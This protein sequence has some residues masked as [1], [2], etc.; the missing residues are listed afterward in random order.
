MSLSNL[1]I[2]TKL[3]AGFGVVVGVFLLSA[4]FLFK[5]LNNK[6]EV[7]ERLL[8]VRTPTVYAGLELSGAINQSL[9]GLRGYLI[10]GADP[11]KGQLFKNEREVA[12]VNIDKA[13]SEMNRFAQNWTV[14]KNK[15]LLSE[16]KVQ[17]EG[18]R[19]AQQSIEDIAHTEEN[20]PS[21]TILLTQAAPLAAKLVT[22][23]TGIINDEL[24]QPT[25][26]E[27][28]LFLKTLADSR[29]SFA[30]GLANIR[31]YLLSGDDKFQQS[32]LNLWAK[33]DEQFRALQG[34]THLLS[35]TQRG[36]WQQY[37]APRADFRAYVETMLSSRGG[38]EWNKANFW[39]GTKAAPKAIRIQ[40]I[41]QEMRV[42]QKALFD[43]EEQNLDQMSDALKSTILMV[44]LV[45]L[46]VS[47]VAA[48]LIARGVSGPLGGEP[49]D[50]AALA[51]KIAHGDLSSSFSGSKEARGLYRSM[52]NMNQKLKTLVNSIGSASQVVSDTAT[53]MSGIS[54]QT[55]KNVQEQYV[56]TEYVATAIEEMTTTVNDI[57]R[58][59]ADCADITTLTENITKTGEDNVNG[60]IKTIHNLN[61]EINH[62]TEV[63]VALQ[64]KSTSIN[65]VSEVIANIAEQTN[66]LALNAAIEAARAGEQGR[67]FAVVAD[68]VRSLAS[69]TQESIA[70]INTIIDSLQQG[71]N[72]AVVVMKKS[73]QEALA[74]IDEAKKS[75]DSLRE[76]SQSVQNIG[77][78]AQQIAVASEE[79]S[80]VITEISRNV[81]EISNLA[82]LTS[83]GGPK[84]V[85]ASDQLSTQAQELK[86][87]ISSFNLGSEG[88]RV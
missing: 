26:V 65:S 8:N 27:R 1:T 30:L 60:S 16:L 84:A 64:Q 67:G 86:A 13:L 21:I 7:Q 20:I 82:Q 48:L 88:H 43:N 29:A 61:T 36:Y 73:Q 12:W 24:N 14:A 81:Q 58:N 85:E 70:S 39:L 44:V 46:I 23:L 37:R 71:A 75:G 31:A 45:S 80:S 41:L 53:D 17:V 6:T 79:Q 49:G 55:N 66:L 18:F 54:S 25:T 19:D 62:A 47:V 76:I 52:I 2:R 59:A 50:M 42:S 40:Q 78:M 10:L 3:F 72:E 4:L 11:E 69:K 74:T 28:K 77:G 63:I 51:D 9:S 33:N 34:M 38:A 57:A 56:Q 87:L 5:E 68:E 32:F 83:E 35:E 22:A 15:A